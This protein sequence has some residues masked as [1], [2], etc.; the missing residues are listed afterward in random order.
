MQCFFMVVERKQVTT[1]R[2]A[3]TI[4]RDTSSDAWLIVD[5]Y[6]LLLNFKEKNCE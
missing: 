5:L 6:H 3:E 1:L 4:I 2:Y